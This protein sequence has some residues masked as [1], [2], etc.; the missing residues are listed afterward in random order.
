MSEFYCNKCR[1]FKSISELKSKS[2]DGRVKTCIDCSARIKNRTP[3][4]DLSRRKVVIDG[5]IYQLCTRI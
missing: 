1:L 4:N 3:S 2:A 5:D